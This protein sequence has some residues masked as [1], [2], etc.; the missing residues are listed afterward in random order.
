MGELV[1]IDQNVFSPKGGDWAHD[2]AGSRSVMPTASALVG[3]LLLGVELSACSPRAGCARDNAIASTSSPDAPSGAAS[4]GVAESSGAFTKRETSSPLCELLRERVEL[5]TMWR[6]KARTL[7]GSKDALCEEAAPP[8]VCGRC[9]VDENGLMCVSFPE[10][11][12]GVRFLIVVTSSSHAIRCQTLGMLPAREL[13][14]GIERCRPVE[15]GAL[16]GMSFVVDGRCL[17]QN[18][19]IFDSDYAAYVRD[20]VADTAS[21]DS[22]LDASAPVLK[23]GQIT[24]EDA[25]SR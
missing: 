25:A 23:C 8:R 1:E 13:A 20:D 17:R 11:G 12:L 10:D 3:V 16:S 15:F 9:D 18:I 4:S 24:G 14:P 22:P 2:G 7:F 5:F 19:A 21:C 6:P